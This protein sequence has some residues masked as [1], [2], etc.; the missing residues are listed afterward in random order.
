M[1]KNTYHVEARF[2]RSRKREL[3]TWEGQARNMSIAMRRAAGA[4]L[5]RKNVKR[6]RHQKITFFIEKLHA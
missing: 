5:K 4:I 2:E 1:A 3:E 6:L